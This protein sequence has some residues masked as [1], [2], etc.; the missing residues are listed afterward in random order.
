MSNQNWK[1]TSLQKIEDAYLEPSGETQPA[2][3]RRL[4]SKKQAIKKFNVRQSFQT[5][6]IQNQSR[7]TASIILRKQQL[8]EAQTA[9]QRRETRE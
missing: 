9:E 5:S 7:T 6:Q 3:K 4:V 8:R 2:K 1:Y